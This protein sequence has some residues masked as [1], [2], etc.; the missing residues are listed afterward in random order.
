MV[1]F[2]FIQIFFVIEMTAIV[3]PTA[4]LY[5]FSHEY[6]SI[7]LFKTLASA[8]HCGPCDVGTTMQCANV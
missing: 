8:V 3:K 7:W 5:R 6:L 2:L 1:K 4:N